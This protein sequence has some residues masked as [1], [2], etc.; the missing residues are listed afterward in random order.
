MRREEVE[1][2]ED[3]EEEDREDREDS[4]DRDSRREAGR[5]TD[6]H[7]SICLFPRLTACQGG[8]AGWLAG[9]LAELL[10]T[11][12]GV[13]GKLTYH[14]R[15]FFTGGIQGRLEGSRRALA[16]SWGREV[17]TLQY[18]RYGVAY[19][20]TYCTRCLFFQR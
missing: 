3:S 15:F 1:E 12:L 13:L 5:L 4:E 18:V 7:C 10:L 17:R 9:W 19:Q 8:R 16:K 20:I 11:I 2:E 6:A 14:H